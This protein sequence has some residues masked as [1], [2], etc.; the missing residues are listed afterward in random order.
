M[1][2]AQLKAL[3]GFFS[4]QQSPSTIQTLSEAKA[5]DGSLRNLYNDYTDHLS[6][7]RAKEAS[8]VRNRIKKLEADF[9]K[10]YKKIE[11]EN[12]SDYKIREL[13]YRKAKAMMVEKL[14]Q[15]VDTL[16]EADESSSNL[17]K[18][19]IAQRDLLDLYEDTKKMYFSDANDQVQFRHHLQTNLVLAN[20][21]MGKNV[22]FFCK[23]AEDRT[24]RIDNK[25]QE[26][27]IY[28][29]SHGHFPVH[30]DQ[31][32]Q[33][34]INQIAIRV[35]DGSASVQT[36][37]QNNRGAAGLQL[38][39]D[40]S[41]GV[42]AIMGKLMGNLAKK[43]YKKPVIKT[44]EAKSTPKLEMLQRQTRPRI[45]SLTETSRQN[46][47]SDSGENFDYSENSRNLDLDDTEDD[48]PLANDDVF[49][50]FKS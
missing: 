48:E 50:E 18:T 41:Y 39:N 22:E 33:A 5:L 25:I 43:V 28:R 12:K 26:A 36:T 13:V 17:R 16:P 32:A 4:T 29:Q 34:I 8:Q 31:K 14:N 24:G 30:S 1:L 40:P 11:K 35:L 47:D 3:D 45:P 7:N 44:I 15:L 19:L 20:H 38:H 37:D 21:L 9:Q 10:K 2:A 46:S 42:R 27:L 6:N 49:N 23:S